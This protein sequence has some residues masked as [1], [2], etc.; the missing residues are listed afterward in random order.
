MFLKEIIIVIVLQQTKPMNRMKENK[1]GEL[2]ISATA[3]WLSDRSWIIQA[4]PKK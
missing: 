3:H 4:E 1:I 2:H